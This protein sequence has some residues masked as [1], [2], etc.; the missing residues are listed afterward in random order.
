MDPLP[1]GVPFPARDMLELHHELHARPALPARA[2]CVVSYWVNAGMSAQRATQ[3]LA[4]LCL[5]SG[6]EPPSPDVRHH[7]LHTGGFALKFERHGEFVSWQ[8]SRALPTPPPQPDDDALR[9]AL[10]DSSALDVLPAAF[11]ALLSGEDSGRLLAATHVVFI[12]GERPDSW[13]ADQML[14]RC[15]ALLAAQ[16]GPGDGDD[17]AP[18]MGAHIGDAQG[19]ALL[20]HLRLGPDGFCRFVVLDFGLPPDQAAR[21]AQRLCEIEAYRMLAMQGFPLA[22]R[23]AVVL[24]ELEQRLQ[25]TVDAMAGDDPG[26]EVEAF[27]TLSTLAAAVEHSAARTRYRFSATAAYHRIVLARLDELREQRIVGVQTLGGFLGRRFAPAM[28]FCAS[29]DARLTDV[30]ERISRATNLARVRLE[31][32]REAGNQQLLCALAQRQKQQ[33]RLQQTVEGLSVVA[34]SYYAVG[35]VGYLA[36][37]AQALPSLA[38]WLP[39]AEVLIGIAVLPV[40][41]G[42]A[43]FV[44]NLRKHWQ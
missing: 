6:A 18:V 11:V 25:A 41:A 5:A 9:H 1:H 8:V 23:E 14:P 32:R 4:T 20:T 38:P 30:A 28:A 7:V 12:R 31:A 19:A 13:R 17:A 40:V 44:R 43:W 24:A 36:K 16:A 26:D 39:H 29:T 42:V 33:L 3:A 34:I 37:G 21:E 27:E 35:L 15:Q 22:Q 2:P 10:L